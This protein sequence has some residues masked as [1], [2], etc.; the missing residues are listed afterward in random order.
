MPSISLI[1]RSA[2]LSFAAVLALSLTACG[3]S[4]EPAAATSD[5]KVV[6][7]TFDGS[8]V[9]PSGDRVEV[10]VGQPIELDITADVAGEVHVHSDPE[11]ELEYEAGETT[12]TIAPISTPGVI[13]VESHDL[14]KVIVQLQVQ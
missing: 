4:D 13:E 8:D 6:E 7:V 2:A 1:R 14:D 9:T 10:A 5:P 11:Q 12:V 3:D